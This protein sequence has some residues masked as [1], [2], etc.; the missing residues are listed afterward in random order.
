MNYPLLNPPTTPCTLPGPINCF[1]FYYADKVPGRRLRRWR[2]RRDRTPHLGTNRRSFK[3]NKKITLTDGGRF[4]L[5][6]KKVERGCWW[7]C[8]RRERDR[9]ARG[10]NCNEKAMPNKNLPLNLFNIQIK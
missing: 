4:L 6:K 9:Q 2:R 3:T 1:M 8:R 7:T 5:K 10:V